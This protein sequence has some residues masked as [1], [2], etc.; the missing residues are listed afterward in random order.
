MD[1]MH[2]KV[3]E[4]GVLMGSPFD[5]SSAGLKD[6]WRDMQLMGKMVPF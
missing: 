3:C 2:I 5:P 4:P 6:C 1:I